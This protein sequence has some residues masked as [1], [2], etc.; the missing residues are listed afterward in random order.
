V[1]FITTK[2]VLST[3]GKNEIFDLTDQVAEL[4]ENSK[5]TQGQMLLFVPGSTAALTTI[6]YEPGLIADLKLFLEKIIPADEDYQ[7]NYRWHD[8][9]GHAHLRASLFKPDLIVPIDG[10]RLQLGTW[11]QIVL[12]EFDN[13]PHRREIIVQIWGEE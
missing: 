11:Q 2:I 9:N 7:H 12:L 1:K 13:K 4:V 10:H 3:L 8:G 5:I 6:E